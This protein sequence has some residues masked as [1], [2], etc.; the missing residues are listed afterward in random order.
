MKNIG[1]TDQATS[2]EF[3]K[4]MADTLSSNGVYYERPEIFAYIFNKI[5][6]EVRVIVIV[7]SLLPQGPPPHHY[8]LRVKKRFDS[9]IFYTNRVNPEWIQS[10]ILYH[11]GV[12]NSKLYAHYD[13][14]LRSDVAARRVNLSPI[15][16]IRFLLKR[17]LQHSDTSKIT[18][19]FKDIGLY[20]A[21]RSS[22]R[23][24][25]SKIDGWKRFHVPYIKQCISNEERYNDVACINFLNLCLTALPSSTDMN[26]RN[27]LTLYFT[28]LSI[29]ANMPCILRQVLATPSIVQNISRLSLPEEVGKQYSLFERYLMLALKS[30]ILNVEEI[31]PLVI[32][33]ASSIIT[34]NGAVD[35]TK[36]A[37]L[38]SYTF[39]KKDSP[40]LN[41]GPLSKNI[42]N[43]F[44][45][46]LVGYQ[47]DI[48]KTFEM[49]YIQ[50]E[51][52]CDVC[53]NL[54][55]TDPPSTTSKWE[56]RNFFKIPPFPNVS[57]DI[58]MRLEKL[59]DEV[60]SEA[61]VFCPTCKTYAF[62][63]QRSRLCSLW[64]PICR[65]P[66]S[67]MLIFTFDP[68]EDERP[69]YL[70]EYIKISNSLTDKT[71][72]AEFRLF[73]YTTHP[74]LNQ[75]PPSWSYSWSS[76]NQEQ[77]LSFSTTVIYKSACYIYSKD[78]NIPRSESLR[79]EHFRDIKGC[80]LAI[81]LLDSEQEPREKQLK[82]G[83]EPN[84]SLLAGIALKRTGEWIA[85]PGIDMRIT[86]M[87]SCG[88]CNESL[89]R[90][91]I[92]CAGNHHSTTERSIATYISQECVKQGRNT[93]WMCKFDDSKRPFAKRFQGTT[94]DDIRNL[95]NK[96]DEV[97]TQLVRDKKIATKAVA[98]GFTLHPTGIKIKHF[99][100]ILLHK[101]YD[102]WFSSEIFELTILLLNNLIAR[103]LVFYYHENKKLPSLKPVC[104]ALIIYLLA[105][106]L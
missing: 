68:N 80:L 106:L 97:K 34:T 95:R 88:V 46:S 53:K 81:Y 103:F 78:S 45:T 59:K 52:L 65:Y 74:P 70:Q 58:D 87:C 7:T 55:V 12:L 75:E 86:H 54:L 4:D 14:V 42:E 43:V 32:E 28:V 77:N 89:T 99:T 47:Q 60:E 90:T 93:C 18:S 39:M 100:D 10:M 49:Q 16:S 19:A 33:Y 50:S 94:E 20:A 41:D 35:N 25:A 9:A 1:L 48:L 63:S 67:R 17:E 3:F 92:A 85:P 38:F 23:S 31:S 22:S 21:D 84:S 72:M 15:L 69:I 13:L 44:M 2:Q 11:N 79:P 36:L 40:N 105:E 26:A 102:K 96:T 6:P 66:S 51:I 64:N 76:E 62:P 91:Q 98:N 30:H 82:G 73:S 37:S 104:F 101:S 27:A 8:V 56:Q 57:N 71:S 29:F 24:L 61:L 83:I 5:F